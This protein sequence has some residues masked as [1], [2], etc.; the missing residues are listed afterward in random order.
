MKGL[1]SCG[2]RHFVSTSSFG[3]YIYIWL[4]NPY[5]GVLIYIALL[6]MRFALGEAPKGR[7][8]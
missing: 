2:L 5:V 4:G 6:E 8:T 3:L 1:R 7:M